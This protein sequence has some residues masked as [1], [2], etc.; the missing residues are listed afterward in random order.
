MERFEEVHS[1]AELEQII[2]DSKILLLYHSGANCNLCRSLKPKI[3]QLLG[4]GVRGAYLDVEAHPSLAAQ[5]LILS[6]PTILL[7]AEGREWRRYG[8]HLSILELEAELER[9]KRLLS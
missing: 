7:F 9:L 1:E 5:R 8:R 6:I 4:A 2:K 3:L